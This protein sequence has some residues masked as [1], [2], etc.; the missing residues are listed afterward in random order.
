MEATSPNPTSLPAPTSTSPRHPRMTGGWW[1]VL[2]IALIVIGAVIVIYPLWP[3]IKFALTK[4]KPVVPYHT[5]LAAI[6]GSWKSL[7][8]LP[9]ISDKPIPSDNRL[10]IPSI[11]VNMP[12]LEG[13][14]QKTLDRGGIW[15]IPNTS[16]PSSGG[17][18]V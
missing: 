16:N 5:K 6:N 18:T 14:T 13:P 11:G 15:H 1:R 8:E 12:I 7:P 17:N 2:P 3:G 9:V 10:V 4:P